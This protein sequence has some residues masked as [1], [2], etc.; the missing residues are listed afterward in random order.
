[1]KLKRAILI[2]LLCS[3]A[4]FLL[5][6]RSGLFLFLLL[7][8]LASWALLISILLTA[9]GLTTALFRRLRQN[10]SCR[11]KF[12][13][14]IPASFLLISLI[15]V[16]GVILIRI[17]SRDSSGR[18][19]R[20]AIRSLPYLTWVKAEN[21]RTKK[22][23]T[24]Y[25][26]GR[27]SPGLNLYSPRNLPAA[28]LMDME[29]KVRH[30]WSVSPPGDLTWHHVELAGGGDL[31]AIV[32]D[33]MLMR[34]GRDS[35]VRWTAHLRA[36]HDIDLAGSGDI[37]LLTRKDE[38]LRWGVLP[39][40]LINDYLTV[41][42]P[43]DGTVRR[44]LSFYGLLGDRLPARR[45]GAIYREIINP[46]NT[47]GFIRNKLREKPL[48]R[49]KIVFDAFHL[50]SLEIINRAV[51]G[52]GEPGDLLF[53]SLTLNLIGTINLREEAV[54]W[55]WGPG[56]LDRQHHP[57]LLDNGNILIFDN[58]Y[59]RNYSRVIEIDP[60]T[61]RVVW[62]YTSRPPEKF[63]SSTR[64]SCQRL[65][66]GDTLIT[67]SNQGRVF[68]VNSAGE[69]LWEFYNPELGDSGHRRAAIYRLTRITDPDIISTFNR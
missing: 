39:L 63:F 49:G 56:E 55:S 23:V 20:R 69:T 18:A 53:S 2:L 29:G 34:L 13:I 64:G 5:A 48:L 36:H 54:K 38:L 37:Y 32:K 40:P 67:S 59:D 62:E 9:A 30:S 16:A 50:N 12:R 66:N 28:Y 24:V 65:P 60:R 43:D 26:E 1:M 61:G 47:W 41:L 42:D 10:D 33:R 44:E 11:W 57:S 6:A 3:P 25:K 17:G 15:C 45:V 52:V 58:G 51:E 22:G 46:V 27:A 4:G 19:S 68:E 14:I 7:F 8:A 35:T 21:S 31:L